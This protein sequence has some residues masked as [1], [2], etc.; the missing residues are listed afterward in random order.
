MV[1][2][3]SSFKETSR[4][5]ANFQYKFHVVQHFCNYFYRKEKLHCHILTD[6]KTFIIMNI[7]F[8]N[9]FLTET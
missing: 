8:E 4:V 1:L 7:N 2:S 5:L 6:H 9:K 3:L